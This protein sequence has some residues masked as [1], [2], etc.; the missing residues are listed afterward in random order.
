M[1]LIHTPENPKLNLNQRVKKRY[2][3]NNLFIC[4]RSMDHYQL[5]LRLTNWQLCGLGTG[6]CWL[7][8][9]VQQLGAGNL[10]HLWLGTSSC[11]RSLFCFFS[12]TMWR[13]FFHFIHVTSWCVV[14]IGK[15]HGCIGMILLMEIYRN[16]ALGHSPTSPIGRCFVLLCPD[17]PCRRAWICGQR[18]PALVLRVSRN[19]NAPGWHNCFLWAQLFR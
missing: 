19:V 2:S 9:L 5:L 3:T 6:K 4:L 1:E 13:W 15:T 18:L 16:A 12:G 17:G 11:T 8:V 14:Y 10:W 7:R